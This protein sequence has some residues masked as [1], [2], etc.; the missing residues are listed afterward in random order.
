MALKSKQA[1]L[2]KE[3]FYFD[4]ANHIGMLFSIDIVL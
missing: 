1:H 3:K 2:V 4:M